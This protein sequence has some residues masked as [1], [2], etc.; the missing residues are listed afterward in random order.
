[1]AGLV[2]ML[3]AQRFID[4]AQRL[5]PFHLRLPLPE[6]HKSLPANAAM[7]FNTLFRALAQY[8]HLD[9]LV[10]SGCLPAHEKT[11]AFLD[12]SGTCP[13][14]GVAP[15]LGGRD[16][17]HHCVRDNLAYKSVCAAESSAKRRCRPR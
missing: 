8:L 17:S 14:P 15:V 3:T 7:R 2:A 12:R 16:R 1:G 10:F 11:V 6:Q 13:V 9:L 4:L 5:G